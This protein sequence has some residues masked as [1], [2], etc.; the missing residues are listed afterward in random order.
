MG[1]LWHTIRQEEIWVEAAVDYLIILCRKL[2][3]QTTTTVAEISPK[4]RQNRNRVA[5]EQMFEVLPIRQ[6]FERFE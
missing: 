2:H 6:Y 5:H 4:F 3:T 1:V